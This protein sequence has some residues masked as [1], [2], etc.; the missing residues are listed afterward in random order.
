[1]VTRPSRKIA[2]SSLIGIASHAQKAKKCVALQASFDEQLAPRAPRPEHDVADLAHSA[3][4]GL[5]NA[6][7][8]GALVAIAK[9]AVARAL[10]VRTLLRIGIGHG[11]GELTRHPAVER[12]KIGV[13][14]HRDFAA[15]PGIGAIEAGV[16][17][18]RG[19]WGWSKRVD[20]SCRLRRKRIG[21]GKL[22]QIRFFR[23]SRPGEG[24]ERSD[25]FIGIGDSQDAP[26]GVG[27]RL[28]RVEDVRAQ[29]P[30]SSNHGDAGR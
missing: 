18:G 16:R 10:Q 15:R 8:V 12:G 14:T 24:R 17:P 5:G 19:T 13:A 6:R 2:R 27:G 9:E 22:V 28:H 26:A 20:G 25:D 7:I 29:R 3:A 11:A 4:V 23:R 30:A 21:W 1:M